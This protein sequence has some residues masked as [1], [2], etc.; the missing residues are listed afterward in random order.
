MNVWCALNVKYGKNIYTDS[1]FERKNASSKGKKCCGMSIFNLVKL[2]RTRMLVFYL[3]VYLYI[4]R[5]GNVPS[6]YVNRTVNGFVFPFSSRLYSC[7]SSTFFVCSCLEFLENADIN[8]CTTSTEYVI[9]FHHW[10]FLTSIL[11]IIYLYWINYTIFPTNSPNVHWSLEQV[12][13]HSFHRANTSTS[14]SL[15]LHSNQICRCVHRSLIDDT[16]E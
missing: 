15:H 14:L 2:V 4:V 12:F 1:H 6:R 11:S 7:Q 9:Y 16:D 8:N 10:I 13:N 3:R 5:I